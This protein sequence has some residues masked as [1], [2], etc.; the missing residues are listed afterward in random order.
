[1]IRRRPSGPRLVWSRW[2]MPSW[3]VS[4]VAWMSVVRVIGESAAA[5]QQEPRVVLR[6]QQAAGVVHHGEVAPGH[7]RS[8]C[9]RGRPARRGVFRLTFDQASRKSATK[10]ILWFRP[11]TFISSLSTFGIRLPG[12]DVGPAADGAPDPAD[13]VAVD[14]VVPRRRLALDVGHDPD[15]VEVDR[16]VELVGRV[17]A[18]ASANVRLVFETGSNGRKAKVFRLLTSLAVWVL[19]QS[20]P[21]WPK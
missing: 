19:A 1:M 14:L 4:I 8:C 6:R 12:H 17:V 20:T 10:S 3:S 7:T 18:A 21:V 2:W 13:R 5:E 11:W 16:H 15:E 9:R